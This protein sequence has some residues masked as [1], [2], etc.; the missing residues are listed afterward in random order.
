MKPVLKSPPTTTT[1][2]HALKEE[3][4]P[5]WEAHAP[6]LESSPH[7]LKLDQV[8]VQQQRQIW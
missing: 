7:S 5:Q 2:A 6:Q 4:P 3:K 1:E 8:C